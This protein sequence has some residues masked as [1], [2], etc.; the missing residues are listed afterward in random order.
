MHSIN[1]VFGIG[2]FIAYIVMEKYKTAY[3]SLCIFTFS[4]GILSLYVG[5]VSV[6]GAV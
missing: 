1:T 6:S 5:K 2:D 3:A 4:F